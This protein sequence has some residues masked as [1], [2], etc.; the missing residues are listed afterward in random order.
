MSRLQKRVNIA[1]LTGKIDI[2]PAGWRSVKFKNVFDEYKYGPRF[3]SKDYDDS[4]NVKTIRGTDLSSTGSIKYQQVPTAMLDNT[5]V[6]SNQ[7]NSGDLVMITTAD[8][9]VTA[10]FYEQKIPYIASAYAIRLKPSGEISSEFAKFFMQTSGAKKQIEA[11]VRKGTVANL[12][13]SDVMNLVIALPPLPEQ[14]KI[15]AILTSVDEVI[16]KTQAQCDKLKDLKTAMMQEL[17]TKGVGINGKPHTEFKDSPVGR[18]PKGWEVVSSGSLCHLITKGSTPTTLGYSYQETGINFIKVESILRNGVINKNKFSFID[19]ETN[20]AL[21]RSIIHDGDILITIAGATVGKLAMVNKTHLPANTNQALAIVRTD[22]NKVNSEF[23]YY[24][25]H[26][27]Y[28]VR[29]IMNIQT[30]GAQPNLSLAQIG[31]F[32]VVTPSIEEQIKIVNTLKSLDFKLD[33]M[34]AKLSVNHSIK[35]ALMQDLLTGKV[36]VTVP[37]PSSAKAS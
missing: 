1:E 20:K 34:S 14:Q 17:L 28:I 2:V 32:N 12:P 30:V 8:C 13:G 5:L 6:R 4:G 23:L 16:E 21:A 37:T 27:E 24:W 11:F 18:I 25:L 19:E 29:E 36:R 26:S 3:S 22:T 31:G 7:L 15:A 9:G 33:R 10:V 35:K